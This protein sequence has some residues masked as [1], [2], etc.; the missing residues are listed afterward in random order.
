METAAIGQ[1]CVIAVDVYIYAYP[2]VI[3]EPTCHVCQ[4]RGADRTA[5][6]VG[7]SAVS[8]GSKLA[9]RLTEEGLR[10][11]DEGIGELAVLHKLADMAI[12]GG[13]NRPELGE[14]NVSPPGLD[15]VIGQARHAEDAGRSFLGKPQ[16][17]SPAP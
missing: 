12:E 2:L 8:R 13:A 10:G 17:A 9:G 11:I 1:E 15:P 4:R 3:A 5:P 14:M 6:R 16:H 7:N